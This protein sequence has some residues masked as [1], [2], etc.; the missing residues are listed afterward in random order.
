MKGLFQFLLGCTEELVTMEAGKS[1]VTVENLS[2]DN[3]G[4]DIPSM[5]GINNLGFYRCAERR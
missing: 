1:A 3:C 5:H 4:N 2:V